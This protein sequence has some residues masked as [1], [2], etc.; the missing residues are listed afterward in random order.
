M[1]RAR[2]ARVRGDACPD[3]PPD[4]VAPEPPPVA[5]TQPA[6][7]RNAPA[8]VAPAPVVH[9]A[10][11]VTRAQP[12]QQPAATPK[13][14]RKSKP[15]A[16]SKPVSGPSRR[17]PLRLAGATRPRASS[18]RR[19]RAADELDRGLLAFAGFALLLVALGGAVLLG[20]ARRQLLAGGARAVLRLRTCGEAATSPVTYTLVGTAGANGWFT[21]NVT[22]SWMV[23]Q[24]T[25]EHSTVQL[26][27]RSRLKGRRR[28]S[29]RATLHVGHASRARSSRSRSTRRRRPVSPARLLVRRTRMVGS[30]IRSRGLSAARTPSQGSRAAALDLLRCRHRIGGSLGYVHGRR[31]QYQPQPAS[32]FKYDAT[33]PTTSSSVERPPDGKGWY[34]KPVT[35]SF[36]GTDLT[37]GIAAC[38]AR[39]GT[40]GRTSRTPRS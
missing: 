30:T 6:P 20:V 40:P 19:A 31:R 36:A 11:P 33:P 16:K 1:P 24:R 23:D 34:R 22:V 15:V 12:V 25:R 38:T 21:S 26:P 2:P 28:A 29:A 7:V 32:G 9:R 39:R 17:R 5:R 3:P 14:R 27:S 10:A 8:V 35:V 4:A 13:R 18:A 37:S